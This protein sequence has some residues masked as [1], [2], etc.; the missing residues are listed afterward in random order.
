MI[1]KLGIRQI[2]LTDVEGLQMES[3]PVASEPPLKVEVSHT[4]QEAQLGQSKRS[5]LAMF[6]SLQQKLIGGQFELIPKPASATSNPVVQQL[7][8]RLEDLKAQMRE[9]V[10]KIMSLES[11]L[12]GPNASIQREIESLRFQLA[13]IEMEM[14]QIM[15]EIQ[16][17]E[18]EGNC[19]QDAPETIE[20]NNDNVIR[21]L[22]E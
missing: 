16:K 3:A 10:S 19:A 21:S 8:Q 11:Q 4:F 17:L 13:K 12:S 9:I 14:K 18:N 15:N 22:R 2:S 5:E 20:Q 6:G 1:E 7:L